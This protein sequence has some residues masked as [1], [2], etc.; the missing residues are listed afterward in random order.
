METRKDVVPQPSV[1]VRIGRVILNAESSPRPEGGL[2][3]RANQHWMGTRGVPGDLQRPGPRPLG[4]RGAWG[5]W[6]G[7][8]RE[9]AVEAESQGEEGSVQLHAKLSKPG[10]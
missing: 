3:D 1:V 7:A 2:T 10:F 6:G 5:V 9:A 8:L 4:P